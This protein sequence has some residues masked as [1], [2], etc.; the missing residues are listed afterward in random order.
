MSHLDR[1][2]WFSAVDGA[3]GRHNPPQYIAA[4]KPHFWKG[5]RVRRSQPAASPMRPLA[6]SLVSY[7]TTCCAAGPEISVLI[8][9]SDSD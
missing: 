3:C 7:Q 8:Q 4:R 5:F 6:T 2:G 9:I 1:A